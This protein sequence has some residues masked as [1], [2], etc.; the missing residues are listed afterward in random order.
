MRK[1]KG[2][3]DLVPFDP[4]PERTFRR[5]RAEQQAARAETMADA[6]TRLE[7]LERQMA[8]R[9]QENADLRQ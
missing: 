1:A 2:S 4:E 8:Q 6:M 3:S 9:D 7:E 5:R